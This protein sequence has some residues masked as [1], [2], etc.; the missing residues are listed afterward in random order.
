MEK[1]DFYKQLIHR[2]VTGQATEEELEAFFHLMGS[3]EM[4][5]VL[6]AYMD[7]EAAV[8]AAEE[9]AA[10]VKVRRLWPRIA[11]AASILLLLSAGGYFLLHQTHRSPLTAHN[12]IAPGHDQATLTLADGRKIVLTRGLNGKLAVQGNM[13]VR[14]DAGKGITYTVSDQSDHTLTTISYNTLTTKRGEASPYPLVLP[15]G[16]RVWLNAASSVTF[17]TAFMGKTREVTVT[18]EA[19]LEVMHNARQP[20][21][22]KAGAQTI[23]DIGTSFDV[24]AYSDEPVGRTTLLSGAVRVNGGTVLRPGEQSLVSGGAVSVRSVDVRDVV[25]WKEGGFRFTDVRLDDI[26]RQAARWYD[27]EVVFADEGLKSKKFGAVA[28]RFAKVSQLLHALE[29]T[30]EVRFKVEGRKITVLNK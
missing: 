6:Q 4:D 22:V 17:P 24:I 11:A 15:D 13:V 20:F 12:D 8:M 3:G 21:R 27:V 5:E 16:S 29:V 28:T 9:T 19:Y 14:A 23:E 7:Q 18:G 1:Q 30:G 10:P 26:L 25:A 2:Y